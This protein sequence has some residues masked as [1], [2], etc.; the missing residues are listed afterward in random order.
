MT[1][2]PAYDEDDLR[3]QAVRRAKAK[4]GFRGHLITYGVVNLGLAAL[5]LMTMPGHLWF[6][7]SLFGW[8]IGVVAHGVSVYA[9]SPTLRE[10]MIEKEM[11]RLRATRR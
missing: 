2:S 11:Q 9:V 8:G 6:Q 5:N 4:L 3:R 10:D 1:V 7:W